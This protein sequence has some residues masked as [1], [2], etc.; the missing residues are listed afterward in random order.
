ML[1]ILNFL[2]V[3]KAIAKYVV[4]YAKNVVI[5]VNTTIFLD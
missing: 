2:F 1:R 3:Y 5:L 4:L